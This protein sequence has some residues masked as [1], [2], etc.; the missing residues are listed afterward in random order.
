MCTAQVDVG[1]DSPSTGIVTLLATAKLVA[2]AVRE[3]SFYFKA[4]VQNIL[5]LLIHGES[6]D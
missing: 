5:L 3:K 1:F 4:G 6:F 2:E